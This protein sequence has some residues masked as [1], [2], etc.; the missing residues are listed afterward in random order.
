MEARR[1]CQIP[2]AWSSKC[3]W[4]AV[5][6]LETEPRSPGPVASAPNCRVISA[7]PNLLFE[8]LEFVFLFL[9]PN[10]LLALDFWYT[11][12]SFGKI[13]FLKS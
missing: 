3:L 1:G 9:Q 12:K 4:A 7:A 2:W 11:Y 10:E 13:F 6:V 5:C 8:K